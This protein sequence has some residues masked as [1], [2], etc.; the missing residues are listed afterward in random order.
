M[1]IP[2]LGIC[3]GLEA[4]PDIELAGGAFLEANVQSFLVPA[5]DDEA[6]FAPQLEAAS[7][8]ALPV[9]CA[10]SFLPASLPCVGEHVDE[11][12]LSGYAQRAFARA[13][14]A[15]IDRIVFGSGAAR[16]MPAGFCATRAREQFIG[17]LK[18][19]APW[20]E[21]AGVTI[22]IE[23]L[24]AGECNFINTLQE[25][26]EIV[27]ACGHPGVALLADTYHM[28]F[29]GEGPDTLRGFG[30]YLRHVHVA[31]YPSRRFP[32][33]DGQSYQAYFEALREIDYQ[34][35]ISVECRWEDLSG[36]ASKAIANLE[37]DL[38]AAGYPGQTH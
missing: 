37:C 9:R 24:N 16:N 36:E 12:A 14:Q 19:I 27:E 29:S 23:P 10:N 6:R 15:G 4:G 25:G 28:G 26:A 30:K 17:Y 3:A 22:V 35:D 18:T 1:R 21:Q 20:A 38:V 34:G 8:L 13:A 32:G 5:D 11:R 33:A 2:L 7:K 31:E